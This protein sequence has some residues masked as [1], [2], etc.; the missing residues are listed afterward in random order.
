MESHTQTE[1]EPTLDGTAAATSEP[2]D[3]GDFSKVDEPGMSSGDS[4]QGNEN[5][6]LL[7]ASPSLEVLTISGS[8][9]IEISSGSKAESLKIPSKILKKSFSSLSGSIASLEG[10]RQGSYYPDC[11]KQFFRFGRYTI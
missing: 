7:S 8:P 9:N 1:S 5:A 11:T 3:C 2:Q 4:Y 6:F 10:E